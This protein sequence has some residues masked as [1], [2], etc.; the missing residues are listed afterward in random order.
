[1]YIIVHLVTVLLRVSKRL[2]CH[3]WVYLFVAYHQTL[4]WT[5]SSPTA[6]IPE[7]AEIDPEE[8]DFAM[9]TP[10]VNNKAGEK[11]EPS[12]PA[13]TALEAA[14]RAAMLVSFP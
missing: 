4:S 2:L 13:K 3:C 5:R 12:N 6:T 11:E 14:A 1:M 7:L 10:P 8:I 9:M